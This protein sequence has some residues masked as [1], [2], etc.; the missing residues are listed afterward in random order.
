MARPKQAMEVVHG[1]HI[2]SF[3]RMRKSMR[4][5]GMVICRESKQGC[6]NKIL[7]APSPKILSTPSHK[8]L[9]A[10]S[11]KTLITQSHKTLSTPSHNILST[12]SLDVPDKY[13]EQIRLRREW[14]ERI[15]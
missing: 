2:A 3:A 15:E 1:D 10:P 5:F 14:E 9:S 6:A 11:L 12:P 7:S 8:I 4:K 13:A